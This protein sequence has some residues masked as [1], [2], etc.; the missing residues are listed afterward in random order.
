MRSVCGGDN[1]D[2]RGEPLAKRIEKLH[3]RL[4]EDYSVRGRLDCYLLAIDY[5]RK[6]PPEWM[7]LDYE[8]TFHYWNLPDIVG[9]LRQTLIGLCPS[10]Y[11]QKLFNMFL[12]GKR[13]RRLI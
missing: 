8:N 12:C 2:M 9:V 7:V 5:N 6:N 11:I 1:D 13:Y 4:K 3:A 10:Q